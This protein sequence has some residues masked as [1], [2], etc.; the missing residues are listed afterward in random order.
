MIAFIFAIGLF[1]GYWLCREYRGSEIEKL[2]KA[3]KEQ[4]KVMFALSK[5]LTKAHLRGMALSKIGLPEKPLLAETKSGQKLA[6]FSE[7]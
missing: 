6:R 3:N 2:E 1:C 4:R 5:E 7:N